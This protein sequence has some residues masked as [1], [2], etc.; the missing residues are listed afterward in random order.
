MARELHF[1]KDGTQKLVVND[2]SYETVGL[3]TKKRFQIRTSL[4]SMEIC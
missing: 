2:C 3:R 1:Y 4:A